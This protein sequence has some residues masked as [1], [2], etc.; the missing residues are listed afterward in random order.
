M[1]EKLDE[2]D[3]KNISVAFKTILSEVQRGK[4]LEQYKFLE[5]PSKK[6]WVTIF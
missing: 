5:V 4:K 6:V 2:F 1:R 3:Y